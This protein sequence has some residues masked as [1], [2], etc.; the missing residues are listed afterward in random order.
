V[1]SPTQ[2]PLHDNTHN[3]QKAD[4]YVPGVIQKYNLKRRTAAGLGLR[5]RGHLDWRITR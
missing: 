2:R 1:I 5:P 4:M 3:L